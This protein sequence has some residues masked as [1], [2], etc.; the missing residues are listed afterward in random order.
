MGV[1]S[2]DVFCFHFSTH[3]CGEKKGNGKLMM[4]MMM[5][6]LT[7]ILTTKTLELQNVCLTAVLTYR[8]TKSLSTV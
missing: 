3:G 1:L 5:S 4:M 6:I 8:E 7:I 2:L